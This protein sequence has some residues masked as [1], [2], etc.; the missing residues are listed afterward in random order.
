MEDVAQ[1][2][3]VAADEQE[4]KKKKRPKRPARPRPG[5]EHA[6]ED[7]WYKVLKS[8]VETDSPA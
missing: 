6:Y 3:E 2:A 5:D 8:R 4:Q 1:A 7:S